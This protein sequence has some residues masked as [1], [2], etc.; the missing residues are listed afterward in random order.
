MKDELGIAVIGC[1]RIGISHLEALND[2]KTR[3]GGVRLVATAGPEGD[4]A[5][6]YGKRYGRVI[7]SLYFSG[8]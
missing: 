1:G 2:L 4:R 6:Q 5:E 7:N 3:E 8:I